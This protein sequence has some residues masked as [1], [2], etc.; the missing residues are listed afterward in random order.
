MVILLL[1]MLTAAHLT[2]ISIQNRRCFFIRLLSVFIHRFYSIHTLK[3]WWITWLVA[4]VIIHLITGHHS[5]ILIG[6]DML[7]VTFISLFRFVGCT[8]IVTIEVL[9]IILLDYIFNLVLRSKWAW[10]V[11]VQLHLVHH[12]RLLGW[13]LQIDEVLILVSQISHLVAI[14]VLVILL[15]TVFIILL[16]ICFGGHVTIVQTLTIWKFEKLKC[17]PILFTHIV[18]LR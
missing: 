7:H 9:T 4:C 6:R 1:N 14:I 18:C 8:F 15:L 10:Y 2:L 12:M 5:I 13:I 17:L 16:R 3:T 11:T